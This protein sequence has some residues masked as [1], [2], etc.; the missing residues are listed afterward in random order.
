MAQS[1]SG[2]AVGVTYFAG[3]TM[4]ILGAFDFL[5]GLSAVIKKAFFAVTDN[6]VFKFDVTAWGWIHLILGLLVMLAGMALFS[7]ATWARTVGVILAVVVAITNFAWLPYQP[8]WS[9]L[10]IATSI[11]VIWALTA[12]GRDIVAE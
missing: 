1:R 5:Q 12:H 2:F 6:Y 11:V 10:I 7:G 8:V 9:V 4:I 3:I